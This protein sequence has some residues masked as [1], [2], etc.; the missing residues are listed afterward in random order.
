MKIYIDQGVNQKRLK[1]LR[2]ISSFT[3]VQN[4]LEQKF[5]VTEEINKGLT[6][7][8]SR[9]GG[10]DIIAGAEIDLIK[11]IMDPSNLIDISHIYSAWI[12]NCDYFLTNN[13]GDFIFENKREKL[14]LI[15]S[16][17]KILTIDEFEHLINIERA[18]S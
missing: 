17:M 13:P 1:V 7:G 16:P 10:A 6:V 18:V 8:F 15:L 2:K 4:D 14:E 12:N 9:V 5:K 11:E 3:L